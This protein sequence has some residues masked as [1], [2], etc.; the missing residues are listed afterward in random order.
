MTFTSRELSSKWQDMHALTPQACLETICLEIG[1]ALCNTVEQEQF[2]RLRLSAISCR[3]TS[4]ILEDQMFFSFM[5]WMAQV[6]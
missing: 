5:A 2:C 1:R 3:D 4:H 6:A